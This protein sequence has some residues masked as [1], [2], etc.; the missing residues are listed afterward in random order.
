MGKIILLNTPIG[1]LGDITQRV[2]EA[3]N[4]GS[5]FAVEDTRVFKDLLSHLGIS[6]VGKKILSLHDQSESSQIPKLLELAE[7]QDLYVAS[8]AGSPIVSDPAYPL[9]VAAQNRGIKV[10]SYSGVSSP[11]MALELS[12]LPPIPFQFHGFLPR[13][14]SKRAKVFE[15]AGYGTHIF[16]EAP[17]RI[18]ETMDELEKL[19]P[20][21]EVALV[22]ELSKK[23]EQTLRFTA[24]EWGVKKAEVTFKGEFVLLV[25]KSERK[26]GSTG[27][28]KELAEEILSQGTSPKLVSKLLGAILERPTKEIYSAINNLRQ[29]RE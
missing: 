15:E 3:L 9:V 4:S 26:T 18:E 23:F 19:L 21:L 14:S 5:V 20:Q 7:S 29:S 24:S 11:I 27:E 8:E 16:F 6:L 2:L 28:L 1:N 10:E 25:H 12:G 17:T 13:E 22:R